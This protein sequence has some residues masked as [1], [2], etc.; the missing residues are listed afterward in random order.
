MHD[1]HSLG[2]RLQLPCIEKIANPPIHC[3]FGQS[4]HQG[5]LNAHLIL[6]ASPPPEVAVQDALSLLLEGLNH[7]L[8][9]IS[10]VSQLL[11]VPHVAVVLEAGEEFPEQLVLEERTELMH[12]QTFKTA[13]SSLLGG[14]LPH[15]GA[16]AD[17]IPP[18]LEGL[19]SLLERDY[20]S[21]A[22]LEE[23]DELCTYSPQQPL[24]QLQTF[25]FV[26]YLGLCVLA[27]FIED[28]SVEGIE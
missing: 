18:T 24:L 20:M 10:P 21:D 14:G 4:P 22:G 27:P 26:T 6:V 9:A 2:F 1:L 8:D 23:V 17:L 28:G 19:E 15:E 5:L 16:D 7:L 25:L 12:K 13:P 11:V 3:I